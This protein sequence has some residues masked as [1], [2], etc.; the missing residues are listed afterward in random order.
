[1]RQANSADYLG[2][3]I[4]DRIL[5]VLK[6][7]ATAV[8]VSKRLRTEYP[9]TLLALYGLEARGLV[10]RGARRGHNG[11][12]W[13]LTTAGT[14]KALSQPPALEGTPARSLTRTARDAIPRLVMGP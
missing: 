11:F 10:E 8:G 1:V 14:L 12:G 4:A 5:R 6:E 13:S 3:H 7:P 9:A 2:V